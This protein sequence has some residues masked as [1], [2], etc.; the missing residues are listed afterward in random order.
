M[1][2][3]FLSLSLVCTNRKVLEIEGN[4]QKEVLKVRENNRVAIVEPS[5]IALHSV[6]KVDMQALA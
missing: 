5:Y 4:I 1:G 2:S 3:F 6:C